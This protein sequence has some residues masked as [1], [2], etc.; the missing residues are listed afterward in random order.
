[1]TIDIVKRIDC[2]LD[3]RSLLSFHEQMLGDCRDEIVRL[4]EQI[5]HLEK[6]IKVLTEFKDETDKE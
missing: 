4:R 2:R 6:E 5:K 3:G 1:M